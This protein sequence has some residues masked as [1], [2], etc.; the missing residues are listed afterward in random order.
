MLVKLDIYKSDSKTSF[1]NK[2]NYE[3]LKIIKIKNRLA[4]LESFLVLFIF[5]TR[6]YETTS[7][8]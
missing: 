4:K 3:T 8:Y 1:M 6:F 5:I 2:L 7:K